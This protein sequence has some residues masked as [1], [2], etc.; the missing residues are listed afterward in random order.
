MLNIFQ[1]KSE[2]E[3]KNVETKNPSPSSDNESVETLSLE[4]ESLSLDN[5]SFISFKTKTNSTVDLSIKSITE[6]FFNFS[7]TIKKKKEQLVKSVKDKLKEISSSKFKNDF[8]NFIDKEKNKK[9]EDKFLGYYECIIPDNPELSIPKIYLSTARIDL[10]EEKSENSEKAKRL[11]LTKIKESPV[12]NPFNNNIITL[13]IITGKH[14]QNSDGTGWT[15]IK[16]NKLPKWM[17]DDSIKD[18]VNCTPVKGLGTYNVFVDKIGDTDAKLFKDIKLKKLEENA[19]NEKDF[20]YKMILAGYYMIGV[21]EK[22]SN[23]TKLIPEAEEWYKEA[24][25]LCKKAAKLGSIEAKLCLGYMSSIGFSIEHYDPEK[26]KKWFKEVIEAFE[27]TENKE[28]TKED[29][30]TEK[31]A[32]E[33]TNTIKEITIKESITNKSTSDKTSVNREA[34]EEATG[35][36]E[37]INA[38][39]ELARVAM[40][41]MAIIYHN[42]YVIKPFEWKNFVKITKLN[43][44]TFKKLTRQKLEIAM[45][46]YEKSCELGDSQSAYYLGLLYESDHEIKNEDETVKWF[47]MAVKLDKNHLYAKAKLGRIL[48]NKDNVSEDEKKEGIEMLKY[49][50]E[51]GLVMG[52]TFLGDAY[53][54]GQIGKEI[55]T[56]EAIKF[57]FKAAEQNSGYYSH[58]AQFRLRNFRASEIIPAG[59]KIENVL[60][61]YVE[62]LK[63]YYDND[64]KM[65]K[66]IH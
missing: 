38:S 2:T 17:V 65:L 23:S 26:A 33:E 7:I 5:E 34:T 19:K 28:V 31:K 22:Y 24:V 46:W 37:E 20:T 52:Q 40:R 50:A 44:L 57:Y 62:E 60:K 66:N 41:N 12:F 14:Q 63:Y 16:Y 8:E 47:K 29:V 51:N 1:R 35:N 30:I 15:G 64:E 39:K 49:A 25:E 4:N 32:T 6:S 9:L 42:S 13:F 45:R 18:L 36:K 54:R 10:H 11:V 53:E 43:D 21:K 61:L 55:N 58:V 59:E 56:K 3:N 48:I 27:I